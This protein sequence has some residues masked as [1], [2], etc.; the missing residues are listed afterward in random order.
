MGLKKLKIDLKTK[1]GFSLFCLLGPWAEHRSS[2]GHLASVV[3]STI[4]DF[5]C[6]SHWIVARLIVVHYP[7]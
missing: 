5:A 4:S 3:Y 2:A 7:V 1:R 6:L